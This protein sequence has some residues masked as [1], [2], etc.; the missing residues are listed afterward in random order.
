MLK[1]L[2]LMFFTFSIINSVE[3]FS[4]TSQKMNFKSIFKNE[5]SFNL[6]SLNSINKSNSFDQITGINPFKVQSSALNKF[7]PKKKIKSKKDYIPYESTKHFGIAVAELAIVEYIPFAY[8]YFIKDWSKTPDEMNWTKISFK[9]MWSNLQDGFEYDTD[10][11][12]TNYFAHPFH[13]SLYYNT[14]R[15]N[16]YDFWE[17]TV[18][19]LTGSMLWE[20]FAETFRPSF[21]DWVSTSVNGITFG[22]S[23][24]R[25]SGMI[26]DNKATGSERVWR[27]IAAAIINPVRGV[28]RLFTGET[29]R[30]F[31]N[32]GYGR[33]TEFSIAL[34]A[35]LRNIWVDNSTTDSSSHDSQQ[36]GIFTMN[37]N[38][39]NEFK[40]KEPFSHF[41]FNVT[42]NSAD[43]KLTSLYSSGYLFGWGLK[44]NKKV[45]HNLNLDLEYNYV[46]NPGYLYGEAAVIPNLLSNFK[47]GQETQLI[48]RIGLNGILMGGTPNDYD[49]LSEGRTYDMGPGIGGRAFFEIRKKGWSFLSAGY[50]GFYIFTMSEPSGSEH[51]LHYATVALKIP[52]KNYFAIGLEGNIYWRNSHYDNYPDVSKQVPSTR[53]VFYTIL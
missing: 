47:I 50:S 51:Y 22:E 5:N 37:L 46:N 45:Q 34:S 31:P 40:T 1:Y 19:A 17:S 49:T 16:G 4:Q 9:S 7:F 33:P 42:L 38:Y 23:L 43:P 14:G 39:G 35:G 11:F 6:T 20:F 27:E 15:T 2:T 52:L 41:L 24:Y 48:T 12:L 53:L 3:V 18:F 29:Y 26:T 44:K 25:L 10:N 36:Q 13:G 32:P 8:S 21:N 28:N 30:I